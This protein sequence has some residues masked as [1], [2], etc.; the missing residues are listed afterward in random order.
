MKKHFLSTQNLSRRSVFPALGV[1]TV[2]LAS[3]QMTEPTAPGSI[4]QN[5]NRQNRS[6]RNISTRALPTQLTAQTQ[7]FTSQFADGNNNTPHLIEIGYSLHCG[8][9]RQWLRQNGKRLVSD[10][11]A[12]RKAALFSHVIRS[13]NELPVG[14]EVMRVGQERYPEAVYAAFGLILALNRPVSAGEMRQ[15][16][17]ESGFSTSRNF[18]ERNAEVALLGVLKAYHDGLGRRST[19]II[20]NSQVG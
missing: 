8:G 5:P 20:I 14:V 11:R 4:S 17:S 16:L 13:E 12:G 7:G 3:C 2:S 6:I 1:A 19:P 10:L 18:S 9:T 15:F